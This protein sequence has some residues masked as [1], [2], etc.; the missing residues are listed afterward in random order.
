MGIKTSKHQSTLTPFDND[1]D[2][3]D[4]SKDKN[5]SIVRDD[6][7]EDEK[8]KESKKEKQLRLLKEKWY[9]DARSMKSFASNGIFFD[10]IECIDCV[11]NKFG[12]ISW[13]QIRGAVVFKSELSENC[14]LHLLTNDLRNWRYSNMSAKKLISSKIKYIN[15]EHT[16]FASCVNIHGWTKQRQI[17]FMPPNDK[18]FVLLSYRITEKYLESDIVPFRCYTSINYVEDKQTVRLRITFQNNLHCEH[19][20]IAKLNIP[21]IIGKRDNIY[22]VTVSHG[23]YDIDDEVVWNIFDVSQYEP[24]IFEYFIGS[25]DDETVL[26][27]WLLH[28]STSNPVINIQFKFISDFLFSG[29]NVEKYTVLDMNNKLKDVR[30]LDRMQSINGQCVVELT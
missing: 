8:K 2:S 21:Y 27:E 10:F 12:Q 29:F 9:F 26:S 30:I 1:L 4:I 6:D 18:Q 24:M 28:N 17:Y 15:L 11:F 14:M 13:F 20:Y 5:M 23:V 22:D 7:E 19:R 16:S 3:N 25:I